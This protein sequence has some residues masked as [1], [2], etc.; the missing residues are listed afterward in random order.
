[1]DCGNQW[2]SI[3]MMQTPIAE[4]MRQVV[5]LC[6]R[7]NLTDKEIYYELTRVYGA[8]VVLEPNCLDGSARSKIPGLFTSIQAGLLVGGGFWLIRRLIKK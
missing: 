8:H 5:D 7:K 2:D 1:M 6:L 3:H 4:D